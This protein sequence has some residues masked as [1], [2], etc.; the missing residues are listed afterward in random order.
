MLREDIER[1]LK[2]K[3]VAIEIIELINSDINIVE[4]ALNE[5][6]FACE[7]EKES[8][9]KFKIRL[10]RFV[11][12]LLNEKSDIYNALNML[13]KGKDYKVNL[14]ELYN[15]IAKNLEMPLVS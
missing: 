12:D 5:I 11:S 4:D 13:R 3:Q 7:K 14:I 8:A 6:K 10:H 2:I 1:E 15:T 9:D